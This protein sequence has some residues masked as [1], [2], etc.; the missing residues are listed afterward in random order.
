ML[1]KEHCSVGMAGSARG[2]QSPVEGHWGSGL[3]E[4]GASGI[5]K[6]P[7][8]VGTRGPAESSFVQVGL[9]ELSWPARCSLSVCSGSSALGSVLSRW[10]RDRKQGRMGVLE[11]GF[12]KPGMCYP[13]TLQFP[14]WVCAPEKG[15]SVSTRG[16]A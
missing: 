10:A 7:L 12:V 8:E 14:H 2:P 3:E 15:V 11:Q 13:S 6:A 16:W 4:D 1:G 5:G 9:Q